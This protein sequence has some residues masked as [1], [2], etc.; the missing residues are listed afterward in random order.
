MVGR[1]EIEIL[2]LESAR[3]RS[4]FLRQL[5]EAEERAPYATLARFTGA[6]PNSPTRDPEVWAPRFLPTGELPVIRH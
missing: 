2:A 6:K 1:H 3:L 4:A 5:A